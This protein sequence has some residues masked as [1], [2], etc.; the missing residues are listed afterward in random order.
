MDE[1]C[2]YCHGVYRTDKP[3]KVITQ[4]G[5]TVEVVFNYCPFCGRPLPD[6][7]SDE[8]PRVNNTPS[9]EGGC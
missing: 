9:C 7:N 1:Q 2:K 8:A 4:M 3:F 5:R 6:W